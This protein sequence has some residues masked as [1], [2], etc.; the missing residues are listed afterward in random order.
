MSVKILYPVKSV[1]LEK[2]IYILIKKH[3]ISDNLLGIK[4]HF[5]KDEFYVIKNIL[6]RLSKLVRP[7]KPKLTQ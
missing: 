4:D 5:S 7:P 6:R 2:F 3:D 1:I